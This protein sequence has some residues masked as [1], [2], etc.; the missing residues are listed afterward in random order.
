MSQ[1]QSTP[2]SSSPVDPD[3][4]ALGIKQPWAELILQGLKTLEIRRQPTSL[5]QRIYL[6]TSQK[7]A[8]EPF[9]RLAFES[10]DLA[11]ESLPT[12]LLVGSVEISGCRLA[13]PDDAVSACVPAEVLAGYYAW[14]LTNPERFSNP[15]PVRYLPYGVWFYPYKRRGVRG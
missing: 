7:I 4:I 6:Y 11:P 12:G 5:R 13:Q 14:E 15:L 3:Q 2:E 1:A 8:T 9:A 10:H